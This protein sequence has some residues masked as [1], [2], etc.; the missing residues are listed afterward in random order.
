MADCQFD[1]QIKD[2]VEAFVAKAQELARKMNGV[3][4]GDIFSGNFNIPTP[5]GTLAGSYT[6]E[7]TTVHISITDKP[8]LMGC[9]V[10]ADMLRGY[11]S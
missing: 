3:F 4:N 10:V 1:I 5:F 7:R 11:L 9:G 8:M 2:T 6:V